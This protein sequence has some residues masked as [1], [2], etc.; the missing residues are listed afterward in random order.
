MRDI[1][2][3]RKDAK[4]VMEWRKVD[5]RIT[6]EE[7]K[8]AE[9]VADEMIALMCS[10]KVGT[11]LISKAHVDYI[12]KQEPMGSDAVAGIVQDVVAT[13]PAKNSKFPRKL[14]AK[15]EI[16][17][18]DGANNLEVPISP[19]KSGSLPRHTP[20]IQNIKTKCPENC[21][22]GQVSAV[23]DSKTDPK[24][25]SDDDMQEISIEELG[26]NPNLPIPKLMAEDIIE[27]SK[28]GVE[29][30]AYTNIEEGIERQL[31]RKSYAEF[32]DTPDKI[33]EVFDY[34]NGMIPNTEPG[35]VA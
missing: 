21:N 13:G 17:K 1:E 18:I 15:E 22:C 3:L 35:V 31:G 30:G 33:K 10:K 32:T 8:F 34:I 7:S 27:N 26:H 28:W 11:Q 6:K 29:I 5:K 14:K 24:Q 4:E 9:A 25:L 2:K 12:R 19:A 23:I 16:K 20:D